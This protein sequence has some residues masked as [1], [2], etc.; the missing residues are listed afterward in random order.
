MAATG[1][2]T[3]ESVSV[4]D[5]IWA[6]LWSHRERLV[7]ASRRLCPNPADA[8]DVAHEALLRAASRPDLRQGEAGPFLT[9]I[10]RNLCADLYRRSS[11]SPARRRYLASVE[12]ASASAEELA[13]ARVTADELQTRLDALP[14]SWRRAVLMRAA[15]WGVADIA[16]AL[17]VSYKSAEAILARSR[18]ALR[19]QLGP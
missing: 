9:A 10:V 14:A 6:E 5:H 15:G 8:E 2:V 13:C 3:S 17:S 18:A 4:G 11:P 12:Q 1:A 16:A 19:A 7:N